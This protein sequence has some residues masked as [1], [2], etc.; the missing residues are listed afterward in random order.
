MQMS[1]AKLE[2]TKTK[3]QEQIWNVLEMHFVM[4][5]GKVGLVMMKSG[6]VG[7][8]NTTKATATWMNVYHTWAKHKREVLEIEKAE[9]KKLHSQH[10]LRN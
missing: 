5:S 4:T 10:F 6:K 9:P 7:N 1:H 3:H 2:I 8:K